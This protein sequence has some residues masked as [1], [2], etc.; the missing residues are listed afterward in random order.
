MG[1]QQNEVEVLELLTDKKDFFETFDSDETE[2]LYRLL[3]ELYPGDRLE[4]FWKDEDYRFKLPDEV[5]VLAFPSTPYVEEGNVAIHV[6]NLYGEKGEVG[7]EY[8]IHVV[9]LVNNEQV[10]KIVRIPLKY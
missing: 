3:P 4:I 2:K 9:D 7:E 6:T 10:D 8:L 1:E 5:Y